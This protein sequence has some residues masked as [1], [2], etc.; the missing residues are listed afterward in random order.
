MKKQK[1]TYYSMQ[2]CI[3]CIQYSQIVI[4]KTIP[5]SAAVNTVLWNVKRW[6]SVSFIAGKWGF[7]TWERCNIKIHETES[8]LF[9]VCCM[10]L[11]YTVYCSAEIQGKGLLLLYSRTHFDHCSCYT[12]CLCVCV[13]LL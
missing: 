7:S 1:N 5:S 12:R 2:C 6:N 13:C 10:L 4:H 3:S 9:C 11:C 8:D